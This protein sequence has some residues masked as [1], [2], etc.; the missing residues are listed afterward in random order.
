MH[1]LLWLLLVPGAAVYLAAPYRR[2]PGVLR[3]LPRVTALDRLAAIA[4][5]PVVRLTGDIAKML[6]YPVGLA[7]RRRI[8]PPDWRR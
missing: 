6:G 7:W 5:V 3:R 2:L 4:W 1:P 8:H